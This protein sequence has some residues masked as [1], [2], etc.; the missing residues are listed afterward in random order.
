MEVEC[1]AFEHQRV[2]ASR[3]SPGLRRVALGEGVGS[4][5]REAAGGFGGGQAVRGGHRLYFN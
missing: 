4:E 5:P 1:F 2:T 3:C